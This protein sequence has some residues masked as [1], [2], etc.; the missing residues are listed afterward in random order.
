MGYGGERGAPRSSGRVGRRQ[1]RTSQGPGRGREERA[2]TLSPFKAAGTQAPSPAGAA[3][4]GRGHRMLLRPQKE[5]SF[6]TG[7]PDPC[8]QLRAQF[9]LLASLHALQNQG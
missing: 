7:E 3:W 5:C 4:P 1:G 9:T 8:P 2:K 6:L